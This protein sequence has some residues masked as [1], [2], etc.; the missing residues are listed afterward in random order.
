MPFGLLTG[1]MLGPV[2]FASVALFSLLFVGSAFGIFKQGRISPS[3]KSPRDT[4]RAQGSRALFAANGCKGYA[5]R[6]SRGMNE[7]ELGSSPR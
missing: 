5:C 6:R 3:C 1:D 4:R 2:V 7:I